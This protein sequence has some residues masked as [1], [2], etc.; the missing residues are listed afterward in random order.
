MLVLC[1][2]ECSSVSVRLALLY[3]LCSEYLPFRNLSE[4]CLK[5]RRSNGRSD[6]NSG[7]EDRTMQRLGVINVDDIEPKM[8][9]K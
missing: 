3:R 1:L 5:A 4:L 8:Y 7:Q 9:C 2:P 6:A